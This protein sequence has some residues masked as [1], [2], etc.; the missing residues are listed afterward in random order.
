MAGAADSPGRGDPRTR[1]QPRILVIGTR[2]DPAT[3]LKWAEGLARELDSGVLMTAGGSRADTAFVAGNS[4]ID[5]KV[6][7]Y[8]VD[9]VSPRNGTA[10]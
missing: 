2:D 7:K 6:V 9:L 4:C 5:N 1:A 8:L 10:C 3:P